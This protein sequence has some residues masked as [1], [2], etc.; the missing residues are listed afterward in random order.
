MVPDDDHPLRG[1]SFASMAAAV[2][3]SSHVQHGLAGAVAGAAA[4]TV[5]APL[6]RLKARSRPPAARDRG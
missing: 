1:V 2:A 6:D 5:T 4:K 3:A